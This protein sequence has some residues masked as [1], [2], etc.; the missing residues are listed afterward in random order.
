[1]LNLWLNG[2]GR[3]TQNPPILLLMAAQKN[4]FGN[5]LLV[6]IGGK[7]LH[8]AVAPMVVVALSA[9]E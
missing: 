6:D 4:V 2:I 7:L 3:K 1:M 9:P 8:I 5:V